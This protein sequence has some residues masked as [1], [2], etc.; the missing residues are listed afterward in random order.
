MP[1]HA[2]IC[3]PSPNESDPAEAAA[4]VQAALEKLPPRDRLVLTLMYLEDLSIAEIAERTGW[5]RIMVKV[6]AFR[7]RRKLRRL[8]EAEESEP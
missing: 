2:A 6:Q 1:D 8:L 7:A 5:S 4:Q 3:A